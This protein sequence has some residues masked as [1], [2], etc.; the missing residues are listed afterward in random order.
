LFLFKALGLF[1]LWKLV[2]LFF[3]LPGRILDG[4]M[5]RMI[6]VATGRALDLAARRPDGYSVKMA[7]DTVFMD[8]RIYSS[9]AVDIYRNDR[10]TLR[11]ADACN[12]LEMMVLYL[13]FLICFPASLKR[14]LGFAAGGLVLI[15]L[16]NIIRCGALVLIF[17]H[18][19]QYL[20]FS[21]HFAFTF[22]VYAFIFLLW[23]LFTKNL[24]LNGRPS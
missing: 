17:I 7:T 18:Y 23:Y 13:G 21:H 12:G 22:I 6:G 14:K 8:G 19:N 24:R 4:P 15:T 2:Y 9:P 1:I 11:V 20:D 16:L 3:F 10:R 5:T